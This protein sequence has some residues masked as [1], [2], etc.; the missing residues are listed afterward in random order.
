MGKLI[1]YLLLLLS[2]GALSCNSGSL[3]S[4]QLENK[5]APT[6]NTQSNADFNTR[7]TE[8]KVETSEYPPVLY[9]SLSFV[10]KQKNNRLIVRITP[11][12]GDMEE[13]INR[14][15][16][17]KLPP[18]ET[19]FKMDIMNCFGYLGTAK[20]VFHGLRHEAW[21]GELMPETDMAGLEQK[22][23]RCVE[24]P[25]SEFNSKYLSNWVF[26]I[27][28]TDEKRKQV[29]NVKN[30]DWKAIIP[31]IPYE[32]RKVAKLPM[33]PTDKQAKECVENWL[34]SDGDGKIDILVLCALNEENTTESGSIWRYS[35]V[36]QMVNGR[37]RE[38][39]QTADTKD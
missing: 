30:P 16:D 35:R 36:L 2:S 23:R 11:T 28:P 29:Q 22:M 7:Q 27:A 17:M 20:V 21:T 15:F 31:T 13:T 25:N 37:W 38:R 5:S 24:E 14:G 33:F 18:T 34:D 10:D 4:A 39:W 19:T 26:F 6:N 9:G 12:G 8:T 3:T 32:W 1:V